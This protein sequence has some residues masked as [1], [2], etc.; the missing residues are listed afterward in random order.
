MWEKDLEFIEYKAAV[1]RSTEPQQEIINRIWIIVRDI[2][3]T[4]TF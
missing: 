1:L 3:R 4:V 2:R